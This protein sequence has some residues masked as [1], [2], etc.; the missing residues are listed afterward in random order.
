[1]TNFTDIR[2]FSARPLRALSR[3]GASGR[4]QGASSERLLWLRAIS[5]ADPSA[6]IPP[7][8]R[9][10]VT[11]SPSSSSCSAAT[12]AVCTSAFAGQLGAE[13]FARFRPSLRRTRECGREKRSDASPPCR[14]WPTRASCRFS[15]QETAK[16]AGGARDG[17]PPLH[18]LR[19]FGRITRSAYRA[20]CGATSPARCR[21][22]RASTG[23]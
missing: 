13:T 11:V 19:Y 23:A 9:E 4:L 21:C 20:S 15:A 22:L 8:R 1:M 3:A 5:I 2:D 7:K 17:L 10:A 16:A 12:T 6:V 14:Q 18:H